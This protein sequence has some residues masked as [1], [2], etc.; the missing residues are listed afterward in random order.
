MFFTDRDLYGL[1]WEACY[2]SCDI[3]TLKIF[4]ISTNTEHAHT[5]RRLKSAPYFQVSQFHFPPVYIGQELFYGSRMTHW[6]QWLFFSKRKYSHFSFVRAS[7][8]SKCMNEKKQ[9]HKIM[10]NLSFFSCKAHFEWESR[11]SVNELN[12]LY[13]NALLAIGAPTHI[14]HW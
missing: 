4:R 3:M 13:Y 9:Q 2:R 7:L 12:L 10:F 5:V 11:P 14:S 1:F 8:I 6:L